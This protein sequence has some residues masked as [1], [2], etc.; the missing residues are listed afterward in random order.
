MKAI[1]KDCIIVQS[2]VMVAMKVL[3]ASDAIVEL[4]LMTAP[5][6][7]PLLRKK[8]ENPERRTRLLSQP[9]VRCL[10]AN[11]SGWKGFKCLAILGTLM[12]KKSVYY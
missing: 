12:L 3:S 4:H 11:V 9:A 10:G 1:K 8:K 5:I 2:R 7:S 6:E